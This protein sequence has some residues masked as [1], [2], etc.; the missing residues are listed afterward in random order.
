VAETTDDVTASVV[1]SLPVPVPEEPPTD[2]TH[3]GV[4]GMLAF[5][6][7]ACPAA[8]WT[9]TLPVAAAGHRVAVALYVRVAWF[10]TLAGVAF[11]GMSTFTG[12]PVSDAGV[13]LVPSRALIAT[14]AVPPSTAASATTVARATFDLPSLLVTRPDKDTNTTLRRLPTIKQHVS[15]A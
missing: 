1:A 11:P 14:G 3:S 9:A 5:G 8:A 2:C 4:P 6:P 7:A 10:T 13:L 15:W 12:T